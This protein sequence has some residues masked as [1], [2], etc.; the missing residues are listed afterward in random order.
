MRA[1]Q[2]QVRSGPQDPP[3][4]PLPS[5]RKISGPAP[6]PHIPDGDKAT[7]LAA[8]RERA[9]T[10]PPAIALGSLRTIMVFASG[11]PDAELMLVGEAPGHHEE[12]QREPFVGPAGQKLNDILRA[13]GLSRE[14]VYISNLV[15]FRPSLPR[16]TT[17]N[18][19]PTKEE[20]AAC[21]E[22]VLAEISIV[23]PKLVIALG[24]TAAEGLLGLDGTV[25]SMRGSWHEVNGFPAR[26]T[27]HP[28][29]LLQSGGSTTAKRALWE[30]ML[31]AMERLGLPISEKQ[32]SY[33]LP[34]P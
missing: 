34:K 25:A 1:L 10:W 5:A 13:M 15:K 16:Q 31:V 30:D 21:R 33:F 14:A 2:Q 6:L 27:Y 18:R 28:S 19:K 32:Q 26:V 20:M 22:L 8:L 11:D 3:A 23:R 7:R 12:K 24:A 29:Y 17:N 9:E 4:A